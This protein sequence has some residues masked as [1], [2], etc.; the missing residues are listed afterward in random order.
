MQT[1]KFAEITPKDITLEIYLSLKDFENKVLYNQ[2]DIIKVS[3]STLQ[4]PIDSLSDRGQDQI[5]DPTVEEQ[6]QQAATPNWLT[7]AVALQYTDHMADNHTA[8]YQDTGKCIWWFIENTSKFEL[9]FV[10]RCT[11]FRHLCY[12]EGSVTISPSTFCMLKSIIISQVANPPFYIR[13]R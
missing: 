8:C 7:M 9:R 11:Y 2:Q 13:H 4:T 3:D 6:P 1:V 5:T 10:S 12:T